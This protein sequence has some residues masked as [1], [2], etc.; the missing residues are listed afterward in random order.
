MDIPQDIINKVVHYEVQLGDVYKITMG[1]EDGITPKNGY[2]ERYKLFV[3]LGLDEQGNIYGGV[4]INS[5]LNANLS[6]KITDYYMPIKSDDYAFLSHDSFINCSQLKT[7]T[8]NKLLSGCKVGE[9]TQDDYDL[10]VGTLIDSPNETKARLRQFG[11][12]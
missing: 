5:K 11:L 3:V 1:Q 6:K 8:T 12:I 10:I 9:I 4:V 2:E 7:T